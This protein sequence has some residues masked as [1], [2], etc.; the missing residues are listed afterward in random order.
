MKKISFIFTLLFSIITF[1][2]PSYGE[3]KFVIQN[4]GGSNFYVETDKLRKHDGNIF[5]WELVD[6]LK[7]DMSYLVQGK[8]HN[9]HPSAANKWLVKESQWFDI[10]TAALNNAFKTIYL[11]YKDWVVRAKKQGNFTKEN[12][13]YTAM[14]EKLGNILKEKTGNM[15]QQ[16][17]LSLPKLKKVGKND[18]PELP[19]LKLP[20]L[21]KL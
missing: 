7:P 5:V 11:K 16:V 15:P 14:K 6:F 9:V 18:K 20:K 10:D 21:Q 1:V 13:S 3:W 12:F 17:G 8:L 19:K 2:S 4:Q